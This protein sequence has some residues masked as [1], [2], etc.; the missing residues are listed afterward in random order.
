LHDGGKTSERAGPLLFLLT[1]K[2]KLQ[3]L[4]SGSALVVAQWLWL[5]L[6]C[7]SCRNQLNNGGARQ[8]MNVDFEFLRRGRRA[9]T[10][11]S[12]VRA[13]RRQQL[14]LI[15]IEIDLIFAFWASAFPSLCTSAAA[16]AA[17]AVPGPNANAT[18]RFSFCFSADVVVVAGIMLTLTARM[19]IIIGASRA[20]PTDWLNALNSPPCRHRHRR[21]TFLSPVAAK[22]I[23]FWVASL[24]GSLNPRRPIIANCITP[25]VLLFAFSLLSFCFDWQPGLILDPSPFGRY[26]YSCGWGI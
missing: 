3:R 9:T 13:P 25:S 1:H 2:Y 8:L 15:Q 21:L 20:W 12:A 10:T 18:T 22:I 6:L 24:G 26:Y 23:H 17:A 14:R 5:F 11:P 4:N 19:E 7:Y 16:D